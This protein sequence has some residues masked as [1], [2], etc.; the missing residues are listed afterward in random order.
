M[1]SSDAIDGERYARLVEQLRAA[2]PAAPAELREQVRAIA[3][4]PLPAER[5][6]RLRWTLAPA[7]AAAIAV[8][9]AVAVVSWRGGGGRGATTDSALSQA[10]PA[11]LAGARSTAPVGPGR[12]AQLYAADITLRVSDISRATQRALRITRQLGGHVRT[13]DYGSR[14]RRG[15]AELVVRVPIERV[16]TGIVRFSALGAILGQHVSVRDVQA[17]LD[18]RSARIAELRQAIPSLIGDELTRAQAELRTLLLAQARDRQ[19]T[20][21]ATVS[22]HLRTS[23]AAAVIPSRPGPV[24]RALEHARDVLTAEL[25]ALVYVLLVG[26]P[27][28]LLGA[29]LYFLVGASRRRA[30]RRLLG[31][32]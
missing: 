19:Q 7:A 3:S 28:V 31:D 6:L 26:A 5:R 18:R 25:V 23:E 16:Q 20:S 15:S 12:R 22:L 29:L 24:E 32:A 11:P 10:A 27:I 13:V 2:P 4:R 30:D 21:F 8:A 14:N 9:V 1:S 17:R